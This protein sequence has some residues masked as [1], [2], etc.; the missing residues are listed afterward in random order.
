M[1][2]VRSKSLH[3]CEKQPISLCRASSVWIARAASSANSMSR[4][5]ISNTFVFARRRAMLNSLP[6]SRD[7]ERFAYQLH[8]GHVKP[9][10]I[11]FF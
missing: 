7:F 1:L 9:T 5:R 2:M 8:V 6:S 10:I 4:T 3:D 11:S